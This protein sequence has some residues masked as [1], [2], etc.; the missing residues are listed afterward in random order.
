MKIQLREIYIQDLSLHKLLHIYI[1]SF[2]ESSKLQNRLQ[3]MEESDFFT[4]YVLSFK[5]LINLNYH[6]S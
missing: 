2:W 5:F 3:H 6:L 1:Y 4:E